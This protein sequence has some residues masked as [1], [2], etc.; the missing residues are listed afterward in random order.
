MGWLLTFILPIHAAIALP[1][2]VELTSTPDKVSISIGGTHVAAYH[3]ADESTLRP[4]FADLCTLGGIQVTRNHPPVEG[5]DRADHADLHPGLWMAWGDL[6]GR[7]F[8]RNHDRVV[9]E[10]FVQEPAS[11]QGKGSFAVRNRY[12]LGDGTVVCHETCRL[13]FLAPCFSAPPAKLRRGGYLLL[14]ESVFSGEEEFYFGDQEEM[15]LGVRVATALAANAGGRMRDSRGRINESQI[16]G[17]TADWCDY[18]G[19]INQRQVGVTLIADPQNFRPSWFHARDYGLLLANAFGRQAFTGSE[20]SRV[21]VRPNEKF[22]LCYGIWVHESTIGAKPNLQA[23]Y[24]N[25]A[26]I[27]ASEASGPHLE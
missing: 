15:G 7:D 4:Y 12:E 20:P 13:R 24:D 11:G 26:A 27:L 19:I 3:Y 18:G 23:A 10:A 6:N 17:K 5:I 14:W 1:R 22:R 25:F 9:H 21:V 16:W 8:W 2:A